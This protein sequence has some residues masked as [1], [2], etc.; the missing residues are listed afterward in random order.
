MAT[1]AGALAAREWDKRG[2][3]D[4]D[5]DLAEKILTDSPWARSVTS[6]FEYQA[7]P[8]DRMVSSFDQIGW[9]GGGGIPT[10]WPGGSRLPRP[11]SGTG[12][13]QTR[14]P[15]PAPAVKTEAYLTVRVSSALPVRQA[16]ALTE[17]SKLGLETAGAR[18]ILE[19]EPGML[20]I[21]IFGLPHMLA[22]DG[23]AKLAAMIRETAVL[24]VKGKRPLRALTVDIP[25]HGFHL[26]ASLR[27]PRFAE[28]E[29]GD[30]TLEL[31]TE[32]GIAPVRAKFALKDMVYEG[33]LAL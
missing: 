28:L 24:Q 29:P 12:T 25:E 4:W 16:L 10:P 1:I 26:A 3:P 20:R 2:F 17:F 9:P 7:P 15:G 8:L 23:A 22:P 30:G 13:P 14:L 27:F 5:R 19:G 21:D 18:K 11:G 31:T 32:A 33:R 6:R